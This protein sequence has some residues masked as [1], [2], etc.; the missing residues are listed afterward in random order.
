MINFTPMFAFTAAFLLTA[1][2][3]ARPHD[4]D[5]AACQHQQRRCHNLRLR[6]DDVDGEVLSPEGANLSCAAAA[7]TPA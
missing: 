3:W 4:I 2:A 5:S 6:D 7:S 1:T